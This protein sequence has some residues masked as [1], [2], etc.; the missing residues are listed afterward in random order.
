MKQRLLYITH[1]QLDQNNGGCNA[2]KGFL[3]CFAA[4]FDEGTVISHDMADASPYIPSHF[5]FCPMQDSRSKVRKLLD[6]YRGAISGHY[7]FVREHLKE[8][9]YDVVVIDHSFT[10]AGLPEYIKSTGAKLI[11]IH[12]NVERDYLRDNSKEKPLLYR[13]PYLYYRRKAERDCLRHSDVNLTV[14]AHD[15]EVFRSWYPGIHVYPWGIFEHQDTPRPVFEPP[16]DK[17]TFVI[18]GSLYFRQS[19][20]PII[21][22]VRRYWALVLQ[23]HPDA[24][25][26]IAGRN[27]AAELLKVGAETTGV[28]IIPNPEKVVHVVHLANYYVCPIYSGSGLKLRL[29]DGLRLGLPVLCHEVAANGYEKVKESGFLFTYHDEASFSEALQKLSSAS[30]DPEKVFQSFQDTFSLSNGIKRLQNILQESFESTANK[31]NI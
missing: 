10:G 28:T 7:Y 15:A 2:S 3:R 20:L 16:K 4:L 19:L 26:I 5:Q 23:A 12:H 30:I 17:H 27:P 21:D 13:L 14:T 11:T 18:T 6:M 24:K 31:K 8:H 1:H 9:Q 29:F 22:F 25:L